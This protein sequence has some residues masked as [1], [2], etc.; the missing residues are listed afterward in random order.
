MVHKDRVARSLFVDR[1]KNVI[2]RVHRGL[3]REKL[4]QLSRYLRH[5]PEADKKPIRL[6]QPDSLLDGAEH[7]PHVVGVADRGD[8]FFSVKELLQ[9]FSPIAGDQNNPGRYLQGR[10]YRAQNQRPT[11]VLDHGLP[12]TH[13]LGETCTG[14]YT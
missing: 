5:I 2:L 10:I 1:P 9:F 11:M 13:S 12:F 6:D 14:Y 8:S 3:C 4:K 7:S